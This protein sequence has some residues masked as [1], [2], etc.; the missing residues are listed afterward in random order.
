[1]AKRI[2]W[3]EEELKSMTEWDAKIDA[4][5]MT[6][7]DYKLSDFVET[8]LFPDHHKKVEKRAIK[9]KRIKDR[10]VANGKQT[11][12]VAEQKQY[13]EDNKERIKARRAEYYKK[14]KETIAGKQKAYRAKKREEKRARKYAVS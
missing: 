3:T 11:E 1:M 4:A 8:L 12:Y 2:I 9:T 14:N 10:R 6:C 7:D 5:P 13:R